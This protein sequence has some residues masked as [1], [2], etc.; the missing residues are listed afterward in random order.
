M[1]DFKLQIETLSSIT[2]ETQDELQNK[3]EYCKSVFSHWQ[4]EKTECV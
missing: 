2:M 1:R 4:L 3:A